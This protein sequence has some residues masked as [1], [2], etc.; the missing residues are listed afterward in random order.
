MKE[1]KLE[2]AAKNNSIAEILFLKHYGNRSDN[3]ATA[4]HNKGRILMLQGKNKQALK[5]L[6]DSK[7]LQMEING[8]VYPNTDK[9]IQEL[10][11]K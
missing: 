4:L 1:N 6:L 10:E 5:N 7:Q 11:K 9:Y 3:Y 2:E 8:N